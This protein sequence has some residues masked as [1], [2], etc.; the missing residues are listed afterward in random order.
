MSFSILGTGSAIPETVVTNDDLA[1]F[2]DT[3]D[4]WIS[5]RTGIRER[6]VSAGETASQLATAAASRALKNASV[7][8]GE[9][10]L[11]ICST[12]GGEYITPTT[13]CMVQQRIGARCPAFDVNG[14][15][16][17]FITALDIAKSYFDAGRTDKILVV[18]SEQMTRYIDWSDRSSCVLFGDAAGAVLLGRG[19]NLLSIVT[20]TA[21][22]DTLLTIGGVR[23]SSPYLS[24]AAPDSTLFMDGGE[25]YK[26][27]VNAMARDVAEAAAAAAIEVSD[28]SY[29]LSHQANL[30]IIQATQKKLGIGAERFC[31]NIDKRGNTS[32][33]AI[34]LLLDECSS[35]GKFT[36]GDLLAMCAFGGGL[37]DGACI[38]RWN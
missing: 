22:N 6:R 13:A 16:A 15:C 37:S 4:E 32:S 12:I 38:I 26:Y 18:S 28:I 30:R 5:Q 1:E 36:R 20:H 27:A 31:V 21:G 24:A 17:G 3:S 14:A 23:G 11:I 2:L 29:V 10:D 7:K 35:Q 34:P 25:V 19:E 9:I 8:P 33:A